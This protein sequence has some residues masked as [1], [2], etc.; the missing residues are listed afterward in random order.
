MARLA[1]WAA[2][3]A[4]AMTVGLVVWGLF[5]AEDRVHKPAFTLGIP[6]SR[7]LAGDLP[8]KLTINGYDPEDL[9]RYVKKLRKDHNNIHIYMVDDRYEVWR[10]GVW[11]GKLE[12]FDTLSGAQQ[13]VADYYMEW[14]RNCMGPIVPGELVE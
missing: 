4:F 7:C 5:K 11:A 1:K 6:E 14:A 13:Y 2:G 12:T 3:I 8:S 9:E 10:S